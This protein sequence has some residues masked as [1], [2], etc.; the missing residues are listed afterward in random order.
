MMTTYGL[1]FQL[2][3]FKHFSTLVDSLSENAYNA[4]FASLGNNHRETCARSNG[5]L[6]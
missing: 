4:V 1:I 6:N 2:N 3:L 5:R